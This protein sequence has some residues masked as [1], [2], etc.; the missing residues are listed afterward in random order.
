[1][2]IKD[3]FVKRSILSLLKEGSNILRE[4]SNNVPTWPK[5]EIYDYPG[6]TATYITS[7]VRKQKYGIWFLIPVI[8]SG[9]NQYLEITD[10]TKKEFIN[11]LM[12]LHNKS[13]YNAWMF[14]KITPGL[15]GRKKKKMG[16]SIN[17]YVDENKETERQR[18]GL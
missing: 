3:W 6:G 14:Y 16:S 12:I 4:N 10:K 2:N 9:R 8:S 11:E 5:M 15:L 7:Y 17:I 18:M 1:M 13:C